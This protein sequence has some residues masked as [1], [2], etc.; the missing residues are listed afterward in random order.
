LLRDTT[1]RA[2]Q[3]VPRVRR[4]VRRREFK[5][6]PTLRKGMLAGA[7]PAGRVTRP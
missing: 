6:A 4:F 1:V 5:P 3:V 2:V 7:P